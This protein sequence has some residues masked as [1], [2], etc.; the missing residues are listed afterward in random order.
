MGYC[1]YLIKSTR[2][3]VLID[4]GPSLSLPLYKAF[5]DADDWS[6]KIKALFDKQLC[7]SGISVQVI[8]EKDLEAAEAVQIGGLSFAGIDVLYAVG[9]Y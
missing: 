8:A 4:K 9:N 5:N 2:K 3:P 1:L 7:S 6:S